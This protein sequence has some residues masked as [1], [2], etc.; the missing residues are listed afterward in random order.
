MTIISIKIE[1]KK[2]YGRKSR[3]GT[4][5]IHLN[6]EYEADECGAY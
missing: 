6:N 3:N 4:H 5:K 1:I 2:D